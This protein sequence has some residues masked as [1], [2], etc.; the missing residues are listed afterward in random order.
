LSFTGA[1]NYFQLS[2][3]SPKFRVNIPFL[4]EGDAVRL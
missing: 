3:F 4:S 2:F 1:Q